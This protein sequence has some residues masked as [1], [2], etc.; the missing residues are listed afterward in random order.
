MDYESTT[1]KLN[2]TIFKVRNLPLRES[3]NVP[4]DPQVR[5]YLLPDDRCQ[6]QTETK[7]KTRNPNFGDRFNFQ[8]ARDHLR[9]RS[10]RLSVFDQGRGRRG[11]VIG[12]VLYSLKDQAS[13]GEQT[14]RDLETLSEVGDHMIMTSSFLNDM[15]HDNSIALLRCFMRKNFPIHNEKPLP[16]L[17]ERSR[18]RQRN[19]DVAINVVFTL[20][21]G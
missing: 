3:T 13:F 12:H 11:D 9:Q 17:E 2:V 4:P 16:Y 19:I 15:H 1:E 14:W 7:R 18:R 6:H 10:L 5:L 20:I 21:H 8:V